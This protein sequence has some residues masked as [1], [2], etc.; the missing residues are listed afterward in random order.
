MLK[1]HCS[2]VSHHTVPAVMY[3]LFTSLNAPRELA[4][5]DEEEDAEDVPVEES[6]TA[7]VPQDEREEGKEEE[8][9]LAEYGLDK[10]DEEDAG[11]EGAR[12][13]LVI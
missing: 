9:E 12:C 11:E 6:D 10:Y 4:A 5:E 3:F 2:R 1:A 8:D 7:E 13:S